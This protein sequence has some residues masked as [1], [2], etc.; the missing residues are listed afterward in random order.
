MRVSE[1]PAKE[2]KEK[3]LTIRSLVCVHV[4]VC[5]GG[6][7]C[8]APRVAVCVCEAVRGVDGAGTGAGLPGFE[9]WLCPLLGVNIA[10]SYSASPFLH[11]LICGTGMII[12]A[13]SCG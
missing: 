3:G 6:R 9:S 4:C 13:R 10:V 5:T 12:T 7:A 11:F 2:E 8:T 1:G